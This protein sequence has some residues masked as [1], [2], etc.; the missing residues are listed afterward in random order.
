MDRFRLEILS[1]VTFIADNCHNSSCNSVNNQNFHGIISTAVSIKA[2]RT[3]T[4][5]FCMFKPKIISQMKSCILPSVP[6]AKAK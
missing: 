4:Y 3:A 2:V 5:V 6:R 1:F